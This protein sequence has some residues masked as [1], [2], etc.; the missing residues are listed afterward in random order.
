M[1]SPLHGRDPVEQLAEE[2][3]DRYRRGERPSLSEYTL[4][5]PELAD[6][7]RRLFPALVLMEEL[8]EAVGKGAERSVPAGL[9]RLGEYRILREV[10]RGGM[11]LVFEAV[12]EPLGRHVA[13]KVLPPALCR[14]K[15][16]ERFRRE[17]KAAARLHHTNIVPV[18]GVGADAG[19]HFYVM[20][21]ID[22]RGLD[23]VLHEVRRLREGVGGPSTELPP[24]ERDVSGL[25]LGLLSGRF[26]PG[27]FRAGAEEP[28][29]TAVLSAGPP[30]STPMGDPY[31]Q[32]VA[33]LGLQAAEALHHAHTQGVLHRDVKPSNLLLD[34][35]GTVW[36][37]DFG[38]AKADDSDDLTDTGDLVGTLRYMA[39]EQLQ[40]RCDARSDV[41][42]LGVTLFELLALRPAFDAPQRMRLMDQVAR[43]AAPPLRQLAPRVPRDLETVVNKAMAREP[44]DRYASAREL[45]DDLGR[46]LSD[47]PVQ[48]RRVTAAERLGRWCRRHP[49]VAALSAAV[50]TLLAA[51]AAGGWWAAARLGRQ[52]E[53]VRHAEQDMTERLWEAR[54]AQARAGRAS[55]LPGQR[56][57]SLEALTE[58]ARI[59]PTRELRNEAVACLALADV[60][61]EREWDADLETDR[62]TL[63]TGVAFDPSLEHYAYTSA[64][65]TVC[66][67][68]VADDRLVASLAGPRG[69]A[70]FL[71]FSPDGHYLAARYT[72]SE[73][74]CWVWD[75]RAGKK[76]FG[77]SQPPLFTLAMDFLPDS[78]SFILGDKQGLETVG[79]PSGQTLGTTRLDV[80]P[81]WVAVAPGQ[82]DLVAVCGLAEPAKLR[83]VQV[84][85]GRVVA[86]WDQVPTQLVAVAWHPDGRLLVASGSDGKLYSFDLDSRRQ[87]AVLQGHLLEA[88]EL[89][90]SPDGRLLVSRGWD[91]TTRFWDPRGGYEVLRVRGASFLQFDRDGRR[92][93]YRAYNSRRLGVWEL[94]DQSVCRVLYGYR[95]RDSQRHAGVSFSPDSRLL[96]ASAGADVC[97][98]DPRT[99]GLLGRIHSGPTTDVL[100][101]PRGQYLYTAGDKG[102]RAWPLARLEDEGGVLWRVERPKPLPGLFLWPNGF[103]LHTDRGGDRLAVV[104]RFSRVV[105]TPPP[106]RTGP[107][108][109]LPNHPQVSAAALSPD[110]RYVATGTWRGEGVKVWEAD[111]GRL[112]HDLPAAGS[113][114]V[115]FTPDGSRLL[116][117][118]SEGTYR[119]YRVGS[120]EREWE[121]HDPD[122]GFTSRLH[123]AFDP[124]G[125]VM[126]HV[127]DRVNLRLVDLNTGE[128]LAVLQVP[129][130]QNLAGYQFSPDG[131][132]LAALTVRGTVQLWDLRRLRATLRQA[133][134]DWDPAAEGGAPD[135]AGATLLQAAPSS[136]VGAGLSSRGQES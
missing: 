30:A 130:S 59:R 83:V 112:V 26:S 76:V 74:P 65:G 19:M 128:E 129:E 22:G 94:A 135:P 33:R 44:A 106:G 50:V 43:E 73:H 71:R 32:A 29:D 95:G 10:G 45:A 27:T 78:S 92:L 21:F 82:G 96:A 122:T 111:T 37:T 75:W 110:G 98:W 70:D 131:R 85:S 136:P 41:Y 133:G 13:L 47:R 34:A 104:E 101:D 77:R 69:P 72:T 60:R 103:Q 116:V 16:L 49:A 124:D 84:P 7:V 5:H 68:A 99:G 117:L 42:G 86:S 4:R 51:G 31:Y 55:R 9:T 57:K 61:V 8:G 20:Q 118:E 93:A 53:A 134:L 125:R 1:S 35:G 46:F 115:A 113:A 62:L 58:A 38:L 126:A 12:Q 79:L 28:A 120:W 15:Y 67:R 25:A 119:S 80:G 54:L 48:A 23:R 89:A 102:T 97:L 63:S 52:V 3:L 132:Y 14:D 121:R 40:G 105:L 39:P 109:S 24:G 91:G 11:G 87:P 100:F 123:A 88:R 107:H 127:S 81:G 18:F 6:H 17:A 2:F 66:V 114:G 108:T 36:V 90:F 56:F 64:D